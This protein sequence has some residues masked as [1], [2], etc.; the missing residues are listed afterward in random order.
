MGKKLGRGLSALLPDYSAVDDGEK[1]AFAFKNIEI[2]QIRKNPFQPRTVFND[3]TIDNL[4]LSIKENGLVQPIVLRTTEDGSY[5]LISGERRFL[6]VKK[7]G[8]DTIPAI[9]KDSVDDKSSMILALIENIQR[10]ELNSIDLALA[11]VD[12]IRQHNYTQQQ[13]AEVVGKSRSSVT[14]TLRLLE[15]SDE[16][17]KALISNQISEG[18]CK[19]ILSVSDFSKQNRLLDQVLK[20]GLTVRELDGVL[21]KSSMKK[22]GSSGSKIELFKGKSYRFKVSKKGDKGTVSI[23]FATKKQLDDLKQFLL[24]A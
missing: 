3:D 17:K 4:S 8:V 16:V 14:N 11:Y 23:S 9:I 19:L 2:D 1:E 15:L 20:E 24:N 13:V 6:A 21:S 10:E 22:K 18:H 7:L 5:E 12:I